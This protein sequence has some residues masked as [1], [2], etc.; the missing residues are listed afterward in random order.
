MSHHLR[1]DDEWMN[2][3]IN[4]NKFYIAMNERINVTINNEWKIYKCNNKVSIN[5]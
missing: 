2:I 4:S 5:L 1:D 3:S